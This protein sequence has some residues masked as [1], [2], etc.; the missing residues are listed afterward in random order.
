MPW[1]ILLR[2][3]SGLIFHNSLHAFTIHAMYSILEEHGTSRGDRT[4]REARR[5]VGRAWIFFFL[6]MDS[7]PR[8]HTARGPGPSRAACTGHA[9]TCSLQNACFMHENGSRCSAW[10]WACLLSVPTPIS[11]HLTLWCNIVPKPRASTSWACCPCTSGKKDVEGKKPKTSSVILDVN[12]MP[13]YI[14]D[15]T[16]WDWREA[17]RH[18]RR[19]WF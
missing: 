11:N 19:A 15:A 1:Y 8:T 4:P 16:C 17:R 14:R 2:W 13:R 7:D 6:P 5:H 10:A 9:R 18:V 12:R 3:L